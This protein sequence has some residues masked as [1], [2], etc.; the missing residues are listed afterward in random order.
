MERR[1]SSLFVPIRCA[2]GDRSVS[3]EIR[4]MNGQD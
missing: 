3:L 4:G 1:K 2:D